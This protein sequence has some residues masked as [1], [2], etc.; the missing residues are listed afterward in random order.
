MKECSVI[1]PPQI[2][3]ARLPTPLQPLAR[4]SAKFGVEL[5][6]KRDDL[7]GSALSGNKI[8]KLEFVLAD[9]VARKADTVL[10]CGG[11]QSNHCRATAIAAAM[12]G[13]NCRL[14][15]RTED[16]SN[17]PFPEGNILL[18]Q[19]AGAEI[20]WI[21]PEEYN[22]RDEIFER[23]ATA[24]RNGGLKP[25]T[26]PEGASNALG[27]WG[28][29]RCIEELVNDIANLPGGAHK[30]ATIINATGS[31]GTSAGLIL[32]TRI[33]DLNARIVS[34]NVCDDQDYFKRVIGTICES[35]ISDYHLELDF[36]RDGDIN[37]IDGYVGRGYALSRPEELSMMCDVARTEGIFLDPV[38]TGKAFFGMMQELKRDP[39]CFGERII[40]IHTGG[41]FGLFPKARE[42]EPLLS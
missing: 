36:S 33:F 28:Y 27:A 34:V 6:M 20:V 8:R 40:F 2:H 29:V 10:T 32:G 9:A 25:Y 19:M 21:T 5:L 35:A 37:I 1:Y 15:L 38:Y 26:V 3:L 13:M 16:P 11:A 12:L 23:E 7:T 4:L 31:G 18:D 39:K 14:L 42:I 22:R 17:P 41:I 24:L 30:G